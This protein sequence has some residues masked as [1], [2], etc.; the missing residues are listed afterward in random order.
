M[1]YS[2]FEHSL[3]EATQENPMAE[4][5]A[6]FDASIA[7]YTAPATISTYRGAKGL[8]LNFLASDSRFAGEVIRVGHELDQYFLVHLKNYMD[9]QPYSSSYRATVL[10]AV[11]GVLSYAVVNSFYGYRSFLDVVLD[12]T[13]R[14]TTMRN[15]F[16]ES[17][18]QNFDKALDE[19]I[20]FV[21]SKLM[22]GYVPSGRGVPPKFIGTRFAPG[23]SDD[24]DNLMWW[25]EN[26]LSC[27][28][29]V[30]SK[31]MSYAQKNFFIAARKHGGTRVL[32]LRWGVIM[33]L[34]AYVIM[35][36]LFK[37][38]TW[39]G[40]NATP[41][42]SLKTTDY[43]KSHPLTGKP[44]I[45][46]WKGR[47]QGDTDLHEGLLTAHLEKIKA[48]KQDVMPLEVKQSSRIEQ[49]W[50]RVLDI[51]RPIRPEMPKQD[52]DYLFIYMP[53]HGP[54]SGQVRSLLQPNRYMFEWCR[55]MVDKYDLRDDRGGS[56]EINISRLRPSL[57]SRLLGAGVDISV[58]QAI[59]GHG[60]VVTTMRYIDKHNF[61]PKARREIHKCLS[62]IRKNREEQIRQPKQIA[63][64]KTND[65]KII[66]STAT[67]LCLDVYNPPARIRKAT[68]WIEGQACTNFNMCL[69]CSKVVI[70]EEHLPRLFAMQRGYKFALEN[71]AG[72]TTHRA[73]L[74][75]NLS[76]LDGILGQNS[77]FAQ[78][79]LCRANQQSQNFEV[80]TDP[81]LVRGKYE[82]S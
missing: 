25:F 62:N 58:I 56:L 7:R 79:T 66:F 32:F 61:A 1:T 3:P 68:G 26:K 36:F 82:K 31:T 81:F 13:F 71:G 76:V 59:L 43:V 10:S 40:L 37:L 38:V 11:R 77:D 33:G 67:A 75:Q 17:E 64:E 45:Y 78:T 29:F 12:P 54:A 72:A 52:E 55:Y 16:S 35:P 80:Y 69:R 47:G 73:V 41:A 8:V 70:L 21:E 46:Y 30:Y 22:T 4:V 6:I 18:F 48:E 53:T 5:A 65:P 20:N 57:V 42:Q 2:V 23:W 27:K 50:I 63:M 15:S 34:D 60:D 39:T 49:I 24:E 51:T 9:F 28:P 19:E 74:I 14:E 44:C